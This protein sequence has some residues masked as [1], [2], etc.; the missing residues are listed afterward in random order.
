MLNRFLDYK[1]TAEDALRLHR[2]TIAAR[3]IW[4]GIILCAAVYLLRSAVW[5]FL[6]IALK[7]IAIKITF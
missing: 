2:A 5:P 7:D 4:K 3:W 6:A 1:V